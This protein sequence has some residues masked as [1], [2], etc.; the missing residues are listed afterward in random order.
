MGKPL[1]MSVELYGGWYEVINR[2][3]PDGAGLEETDRD[4]FNNAFESFTA[5]S[6]DSAFKGFFELSEKGSSIS[7][8]F[9]GV[10][11]LKGTGILQDFSRAHM[12]LNIA[13]SQGH[14]KANVYLEKLTK[15]MSAEQVVE[16]Q[17]LARECVAR[18]YKG[19]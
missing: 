6:Y 19:C 5:G 11:Y 3:Q 2:T 1:L 18:N 8:Y 12:W 15:E 13:S 14:K 16:A 4:K 17:K 7:Q 10:M 9:L